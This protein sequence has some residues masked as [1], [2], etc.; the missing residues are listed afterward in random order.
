MTKNQQG[1][2]KHRQQPRKPKNNGVSSSFKRPR[3]EKLDITFNPEA[4]RQYLTSLSAKK[5]ERRTFGLA[6]QKVKDRKAKLEEK[7]ETR[8]AVLQ[9]IEEA[10]N[11][12][13]QEID[14]ANDRLSER[15][16][17]LNEDN[18]VVNKDEVTT[19]QDQITQ[20]QFGGQVIV[21]TTFNFSSDDESDND[22]TNNIR[23]VDKEQ[24]YA[25]SVQKYIAQLKGHLP[26]KK[27]KH[28]DTSKSICKRGR[29]GA[30]SMKGMG[31]SKDFKMAK[32]TLDRIK[33]K[34]SHEPGGKGR[35]RRKSRR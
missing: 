5:K 26:N 13:Q 21:T 32:R 17:P 7:R 4:R 3:H 10:E 19:Y 14:M 8:K 6:M 20:S 28:G 22:N 15:L 27:H 11:S 31:T 35:N 23:N 33:D 16:L 34:Q 9:Q 29:H 25:S 30:E 12:K 18:E 24:Q 2:K 1:S